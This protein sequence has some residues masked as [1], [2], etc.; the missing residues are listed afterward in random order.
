MPEPYIFISHSSKDNPAVAEIVDDLQAHDIELWLDFDRIESGDKWLTNI[1]S[2][3]DD[4]AGFLVI[5]SKTSRRA[6]WVTRE[7]LYALQLRK[8]LYI[9]LIDDVPLPL[10]L[11]DRQFNNFVDNYDKA[12]ADLVPIL[13]DTLKNPPKHSEPQALPEAV[14]IDAN[15]DNFFLYLAQMD[16]GHELAIVARDLYHWS[17]KHLNKTEF[18]GRFRPAFHARLH[19]G[20]K[21]ISV[22]SILAYLRHPAVQVPFDYLRKYPPFTRKENRLKILKELETLLPDDEHFERDRADRRPT[23]PLEYLLGDAER[24]EKFKDIL[25]NIVNDLQNEAN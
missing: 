4:C 13:Q 16:G 18:S 8:P 11:V 19:I 20:E 2:A 25:S 23:I 15:E 5:L 22:F 6:D 1:Q 24:L 3:I 12:L 7:C 21:F 17:Q 10:L 9:A 14:S